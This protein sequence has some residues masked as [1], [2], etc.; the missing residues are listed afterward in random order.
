MQLAHEQLDRAVLAAYAA[1]DSEGNW[2]E[3]WAEVWTETAQAARYARIMR[4][5]SAATKPT[6]SCW[7]TS[8]D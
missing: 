4:Y 2:S 8:C 3:D 7:Q 5:S 6:S 1:T